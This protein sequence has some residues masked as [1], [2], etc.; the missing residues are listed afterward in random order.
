MLTGLPIRHSQ[1]D[2][3]DG[4]V[5]GADGFRFVSAEIVG[6]FLQV[7]AGISQCGDRGGEARVHGTFVLRQQSGAAHA[8]NNS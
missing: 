8:Q 5:G 4:F 3:A 6:G 1:I 2:L 7:G